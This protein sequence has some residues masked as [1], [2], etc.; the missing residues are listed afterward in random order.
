AMYTRVE[1]CRPEQQR[2]LHDC[3]HRAAEEQITE[4]PGPP[5]ARQV[6]AK[7][8]FRMMA[9]AGRIEGPSPRLADERSEKWREQDG[10]AT[11]DPKS[12]SPAKGIG[13]LPGRQKTD[14]QANGQV[15]SP[16]RDC[17]CPPV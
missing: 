2:I 15:E 3:M 17:A 9:D 4:R 14:D 13:D 11:N 6:V 10:A 5:Q 1:G 16:Y 7:G 12:R 8:W